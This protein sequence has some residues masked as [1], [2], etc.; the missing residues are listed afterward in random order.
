MSFEDTV[1]TVKVVREDAPDGFCI[2]NKCDLAD[3]D[4]I[5]GEE[6]SGKGKG[7]GPTVEEIKAALPG[8][9]DEELLDMLEIETKGK[10]RTTAIEAIEAEIS[11]RGGNDDGE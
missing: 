4:V 9:S 2:I 5:Y 3:D 1:E 10:N 11:C 7:K 6:P 8:A